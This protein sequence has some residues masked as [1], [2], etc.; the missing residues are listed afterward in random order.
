MAAPVTVYG[1]VIS[2][3]V[4][5]VEVCL[6]EKDEPF[7][8]ELMDMSKGEHKSSSF[9]K[10]QPSVRSRLQGS[11]HHRLWYFHLPF[12]LFSSSSYYYYICC[13][14]TTI[15]AF[16]FSRYTILAFL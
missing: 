9:R 10:L 13:I 3:V 5:C 4:A 11:P 15:L 12:L 2:P 8:I 1:P 14:S 6:L 7:Q 16:L